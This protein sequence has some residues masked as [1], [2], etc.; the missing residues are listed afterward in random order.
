MNKV[1]RTYGKS[2]QIIHCV[3]PPTLADFDIKISRTFDLNNFEQPKYGEFQLNQFLNRYLA[4]DKSIKELRSVSRR[5]LALITSEIGH[6]DP[7]ANNLVMQINHYQSAFEYVYNLKTIKLEQLFKANRLLERNNKNAGKI[8]KGQNWI[9]GKSP[10]NAHYV[11]PPVEHVEDLMNDWIKF[12]N[13][14]DI[15]SEAIAIIGH[16]QLLNIHPFVDGNGR[17]S[18]VFL[19]VMLQKQYGE[20]L[21]P[22]LFRLHEK[23]DGY[24]EAI[25]STHQTPYL[26]SQLHEFWNNS[27]SWCDITK[28]KMFDILKRGQQQISSRLALNVLPKDS[29]VLLKHLWKQPIVCETG[30]LKSHQW[31]YVQ[32]QQAI[33]PLI[34]AGIIEPRRLRQPQNAIIYDC[35]I[36]FDI[37]QK[38]DDTIF[39]T[40]IT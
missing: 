24:I 29:Q 13:N 37:W 25:Q 10:F 27:L 30:L 31:N 39:A 5:R 26:T 23:H 4:G 11:C 9:G 7:E 19:H 33:E 36:M 38:L 1:E 14:Q 15:S 21:H 40:P 18:R 2:N 6:M 12:V 35:P 22:C 34:K 32:A 8:R 3:I 17:T 20:I 16:N 28:Q